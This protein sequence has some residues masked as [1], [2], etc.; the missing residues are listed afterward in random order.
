M[1]LAL[2]LLCLF[3]A[4][5]AQLVCVGTV[6]LLGV[7][8]VTDLSKRC[9]VG[10]LESYESL[11]RAQRG[12]ALAV[13][14]TGGLVAVLSAGRPTLCLFMVAPFSLVA[15]ASHRMALGARRNKY[16][17]HILCCRPPRAWPPLI[18]MLLLTACDCWCLG[19]GLVVMCGGW[20]WYLL[21]C[22]SE[23]IPPKEGVPTLRGLLVSLLD[24]AL[25]HHRED[26]TSVMKTK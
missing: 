10:T 4:L 22:L 19:V 23:Q 21:R 15:L 7:E 6:L 24:V 25:D 13:L 8:G 20:V 1:P 17:M 14:G 9:R 3:L 12:T 16:D 5:L 2:S 11:H 26:A 18:Y